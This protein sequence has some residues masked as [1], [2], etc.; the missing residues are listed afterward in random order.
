LNMPTPLLSIGIQL[1]RGL[2]SIRGLLGSM[3]EVATA[4]FRRATAAVR[5]PRTAAAPSRTVV[6]VGISGSLAVLLLLLI[7]VALRAE[8]QPLSAEAIE[9]KAAGKAIA[10]SLVIPGDGAWPWPLALEPRSRYT[11]ADAAEIRPDLGAIDV[12][13][14]TNRR[15][16]QLE[17]ILDAV[18]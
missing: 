2:A 4:K 14:L 7:V 16:A 10:S 15:K 1:R 13:S 11:E 3:R 8:R 18:D 5:R 6:L 9:V 12:S 17:S